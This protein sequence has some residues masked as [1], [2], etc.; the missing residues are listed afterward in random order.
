MIG[1]PPLKMLVKRTHVAMWPMRTL[2]FRAVGMGVGVAMEHDDFFATRQLA[3]PREVV[4]FRVKGYQP[5]MATHEEKNTR[6]A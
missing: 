2:V 3:T 5:A 6:A 1:K 4:D